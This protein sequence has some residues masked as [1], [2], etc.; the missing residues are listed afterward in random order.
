MTLIQNPRDRDYLRYPVYVASGANKIKIGAVT[1]TITPGW[2]YNCFSTDTDRPGLWTAI[3]ASAPDGV[4]IHQCTPVL[5]SGQIACG[6]EIRAGSSVLTDLT[7]TDAIPPA[8]IG[9]TTTTKTGASVKSD[10]NIPGI[11]RANNLLDGVASTKA[12]RGTATCFASHDD[13]DWVASLWRVYDR[14]E[15]RYQAVP[16]VYVARQRSQLWEYVWPANIDINDVYPAFEN[17]WLAMIRGREIIVH[18]DVCVPPDSIDGEVIIK[19]DSRAL[20][21][22]NQVARRE[23]VAGERYE[24]SWD[25]YLVGTVPVPS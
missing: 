9:W 1:I 19:G 5:S 7:I 23:E 11:W 4:T 16:A 24:I 3:Q 20:Q 15:F 18:G 8:L 14:V 12:V 13:P 2:Y 25:A 10:H 6:V 22:L 17:V 21:D